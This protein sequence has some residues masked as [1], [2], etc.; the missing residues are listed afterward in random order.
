LDNFYFILRSLA[1]FCMAKESGILIYNSDDTAPE[2]T[3]SL[4]SI[5]IPFD[6]I[7]MNDI[8]KATRLTHTRSSERE[9]KRSALVAQR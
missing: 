2:S 9:N 6:S 5:G 7:A 3:N 8:G 4:L 1:D